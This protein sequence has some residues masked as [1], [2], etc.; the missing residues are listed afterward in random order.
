MNNHQIYL[1]KFCRHCKNASESDDFRPFSEQLVDLYKNCFDI[2]VQVENCDEYP[3]KLC[4]GCYTKLCRI[5]QK[6]KSSKYSWS[7]FKET[8]SYDKDQPANNFPVHD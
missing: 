3:K 2:D 6:K 4:K 8:K 7:R 1:A 5:V